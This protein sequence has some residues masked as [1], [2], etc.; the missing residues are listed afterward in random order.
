ML[1]QI[2]KRTSVFVARMFLIYLSIFNINSYAAGSLFSVSST[3]DMLSEP[4]NFNLCLN[5]SGTVPVSCEN[6]TSSRASLSIRTTIPGRSYPNV[7][8]K[9]NTPGYAFSLA[10]SLMS[11]KN[12]S[13]LRVAPGYNLIG[14]VSSSNAIS[15]TVSSTSSPTTYSV[16]G[17]VSGLSTGTLVLQN[18]GTNSTSITVNGSFTFTTELTSGSNYSVTVQT[19]PSGLVCTISNGSGTIASSN[20]TNVSV[21]CGSNVTS[22]TSPG[23]ATYT[24]PDGISSLTIVATGGGGGGSSRAAFTGGNG[25]IVTSSITV[26]SGDTLEIFVGGGGSVGLAAEFTGA[27]GGASTVNPDSNDRIVAGGGG[28]ANL[29]NN[30]GDGGGNG[31]G[32]GS[33]G[34]SPTG[35]QPGGGANGIGGAAG[36]SG[37]VGGSGNGGSGGDSPDGGTGGAGSGAGVGADGNIVASAFG[38][39]GGG[40]GY[41]GGASGLDSSGAGGGSTGPSGTTYSVSNNGGAAG[42]TGDNGSVVITA[43]P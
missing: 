6:F 26:N 2:I 38:S 43:E 12:I 8:I 11:S 20:V 39:G 42:A 40:G 36:L 16:G 1:P 22:F 29:T 37:S 15:G 27:G 33:D 32:S 19:Q 23:S 17:T 21:S 30:G 31:N 13:K 10:Q 4:V 5:A 18:N 14:T 7:G 9:V 24:V 41:G 3:G 28:G 25:G 34:Q 35:V